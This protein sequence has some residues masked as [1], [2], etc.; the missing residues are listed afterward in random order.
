MRILKSRR[1]VDEDFFDGGA[2]PRMIGI[3]HPSVNQENR[4]LVA[5]ERRGVQL[6]H[7]IARQFQR[8]VRVA[9]ASGISIFKKKMIHVFFYPVPGVQ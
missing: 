4:L 3:V 7:V 5:I 8:Y 1:Y 9:P 2:N 6:G